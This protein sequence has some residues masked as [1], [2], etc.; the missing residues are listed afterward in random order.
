MRSFRI[1][2]PI[3][4]LL[5]VS[6]QVKPYAPP[7][8]PAE[9]TKVEIEVRD[10]EGRPEAYAVVSGNLSSSAAQLVDAKQSR[11][12]R[13]IFL[14][15]LEQTPRGANLLSDLALS[16]PFQTRIPIELLGLPP[17]PCLLMTNGIE[18]P[19]V[20]PSLHAALVS[21][22]AP[23]PARAPAI[24]LVDEFIPIEEFQSGSPN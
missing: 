13:T 9:V 23:D 18:T 11:E 16:P 21:S 20:I 24:S 6:C 4:G 1:I 10:F 5:T 15:V 8:R 2:S 7:P 3:L 12:D 17:G 19:F 14:E 22:E